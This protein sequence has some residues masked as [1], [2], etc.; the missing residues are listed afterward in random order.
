MPC[1]DQ[2]P[3][4]T[5]HALSYTEKYDAADQLHDH[6]DEITPIGNYHRQFHVSQLQL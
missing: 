6:V 1:P 3:S 2:L 4:D 5:A